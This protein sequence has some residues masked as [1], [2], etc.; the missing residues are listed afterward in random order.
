VLPPVLAEAPLQELLYL[1]VSCPLQPE[2]EALLM[3]LLTQQL[4]R[5]TQLAWWTQLPPGQRLPLVQLAND[6]VVDWLQNGT[7]AE[8]QQLRDAVAAQL[9]ASPLGGATEELLQLGAPVEQLM[10]WLRGA[11]GGANG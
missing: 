4:V 3:G 11:P 1:L 10:T 9:A 6:N 7:P 8:P 5:V 2:L